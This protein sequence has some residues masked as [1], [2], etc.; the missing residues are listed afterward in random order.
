MKRNLLLSGIIFFSLLYWFSEGAT[1]GYTW[2]DTIRRS[3]NVIICGKIGSGA[4]ILDYHGWR[5]LEVL[6]ILSVAL[7]SWKA[8]D[9]LPVNLD[10]NFYLVFGGSQLAGTFLYER[11][12]MYVANGNLFKDPGWIFHIIGLEI[13]RYQYQDWFLLFCGIIAIYWGLA[14][15]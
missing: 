7:L 11:V 10:V 5:F 13:P 4:G 2:A 15:K 3:I 6:G 12:L 1:E 8:K 14:R 9:E